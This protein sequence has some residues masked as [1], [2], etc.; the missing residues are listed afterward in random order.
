MNLTNIKVVLV[1]PTHAGNIGAVARAMKNMGIFH[2]SLVGPVEYR[3]PEAIARAAGA[4]DV[5]TTATVYA[6]LDAAVADCIFV[7]GTSARPRRIAWPLLSPPAAARNLLQEAEHGP[8]ALVFGRERTGLTNAELD[9]CHA[10]ST[11]PANPDFSSLNIACA[12]QVMTYE[13]FSAANTN[14][15]EVGGSVLAR[16]PVSQDEMRRFYEH[17]ERVLVETEFLDPNNPRKLMRRLQRLFNRARL[18]QNE[19]NILRGILTAV[20]RQSNT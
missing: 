12:V 6:S 14:N 19:L 9:R 15:T 8:G 17:L 1:E 13:L 3:T 7:L 18:D 20:Q 4:E 5:L 2:L 11:I 10:L 16:E